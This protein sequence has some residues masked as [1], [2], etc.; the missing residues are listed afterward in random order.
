[1]T[2]WALPFM[3]ENRSRESENRVRNK[4]IVAVLS[5]AVLL[6]QLGCAVQPEPEEQM[7]SEELDAYYSDLASELLERGYLK[8]EKSAREVPFTAEALAMNFE[9]IALHDEYVAVDGEF[10]QKKVPARMRRWDMPIE[11]QL[12]FGPN[13]PEQQRVA[14][15]KAVSE[16]AARLQDITGHPITWTR[17]NGNFHILVMN[18]DDRKNI[19]PLVNEIS[20]MVD[21]SIERAIT[22]SPKHILCAAYTSYNRSD[23]TYE[24]VIVLIKAEHAG[25]SR[26]SC[27]H[28]EMAQAMGLVNDS[29]DARPSIFNDDEEFALLTPHDELLLKI[30]YDPRLTAGMSIRQA[31]PIAQQIAKE[32]VAQES[33]PQRPSDGRQRPRLTA[34]STAPL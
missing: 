19:G 20:P 13:V 29:K 1:V 30:L 3:L 23:F 2:E 28:E 7:S 15:R 17:S 9:Q 5:A 27:I 12:H 10:V 26:L 14:D 16:F 25:I 31:R 21:S 4:L 24:N 6:F 32:L 34:Q 11:M 33:L 22:H 8:S 18:A